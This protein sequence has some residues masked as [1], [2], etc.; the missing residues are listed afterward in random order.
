MTKVIVNEFDG[1][2]ADTKYPVEKNVAADMFHCDIFSDRRLLKNLRKN[3]KDTVSGGAHSGTENVY[4]WD[5]ARRSDG[6]MLAIGHTSSVST[7]ARFLR[8]NS[9]DVTSYWQQSTVTCGNTPYYNGGIL[10][11]DN[12]YCLSYSGSTQ[13]LYRYDGDA[14]ATSVVT[15][16]TETNVAGYG[17]IISK[18]IVHPL[19]NKLYM[20]IGKTIFVWDGSAATVT[21]ASFTTPYQI[22][23]CTY[24]GTYLAVACIKGDGKS[25]VYL[26]GRDTTVTTAQDSIEFGDDKICFI[27]NL[28]G[29]LI[30]VSSRSSSATYLDPKIKVRALI[31]REA[32]LVKELLV[33]SYLSISNMYVVWKDVIYFLNQA[34]SSPYGTLFTISKNKKGEIVLGQAYTTQYEGETSNYTYSFWNIHDYF[35]F[36]NINGKVMRTYDS[37]PLYNV[38]DSTYTFPIN[39]GM[40]ESDRAK[41][42][43][44]SSVYVKA[45]AN[46][47]GYGTL[48]LEVSMDGGAYTTIF[49]EASPSGKN[50]YVVE[51]LGDSVGD[52]LGEGRD[53]QFKVTF[54][55]GID[56]VE[57]GYDYEEVSTTI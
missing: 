52:A 42:K 37:P 3:E 36:G 10:Y 4:A 16:F 32:V 54:D 53:I 21:T 48:K 20:A 29:L 26:W 22:I 8:K 31:G 27:T 35:F 56:I 25:I 57:L 23:G 46:S 30:G 18:P 28:N 11:K 9:N 14:T 19:D 45:Y 43:T 17:N 40:Y 13:S 39:V 7:T 41:L 33:T 44:I 34:Q 38:T 55:Q 2:L 15:G 24:Y 12:F 49:S 50:A 51:A 47:A 6:V 1:G 5:G